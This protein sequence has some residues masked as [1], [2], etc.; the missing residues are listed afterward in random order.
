MTRSVTLKAVIREI[1]VKSQIATSQ[2]GLYMASANPINP[3]NCAPAPAG[4]KSSIYLHVIY[5][6][7]IVYAS[8]CFLYLRFQHENYRV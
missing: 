3:I 4:H 6:N 8:K 2:E 7:V 5:E 1:I